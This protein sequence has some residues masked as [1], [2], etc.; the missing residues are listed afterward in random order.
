MGPNS[1]LWNGFANPDSL[2]AT[3]SIE[4]ARITA[5]TSENGLKQTTT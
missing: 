1:P 4:L 3:Y 2:I 5:L